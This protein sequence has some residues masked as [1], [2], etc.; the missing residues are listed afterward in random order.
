MLEGNIKSCFS[1]FEI[2]IHGDVFSWNRSK[3]SNLIETSSE[4]SQYL[5]NS[6]G[7]VN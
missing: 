1:N 3:S 4:L 5:R 2:I 6:W 7:Y